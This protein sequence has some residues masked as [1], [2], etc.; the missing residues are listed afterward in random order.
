MEE[1]KL[2]RL[3]QIEPNIQK[4]CSYDNVDIFFL[5]WCYLYSSNIEE[6]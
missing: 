5:I 2:L 6:N 4:T 1:K 3:V